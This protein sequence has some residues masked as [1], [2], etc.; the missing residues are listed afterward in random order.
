M[1]THTLAITPGRAAGLDLIERMR[2]AS[3]ATWH[4]VLAMAALALLCVGLQQ[5]DGRMIHGVSVWL[6]PAKFFASLAIQF[7]TVTWAMSYLP[8]AQL[9]QRAIRW[10]ILVMLGWGWLEMA[11][12]VFRAARAEDSHFN[13]D[14]LFA[15]VAYAVMGLGAVSMTAI[16][17]YVGFRLWRHRKDGL[18]TE[19]AALGLMVGAALGTLAGAYISQKLG[20]AVGGDPTDATG[21]GFFAWSTTG[22]DLRIAHFVGLHAAQF[23]PFAALSGKR[24]VMWLAVAA[25]TVLTAATFLQAVAGIPL[26]RG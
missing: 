20:H 25:C 13:I 26:L 21:T 15:Q 9:R 14:S 19:A 2:R 23:I 4:T 10:P 22:G 1:T 11:Y 3:P 12:I 16:A 5:L 17:A 8:A 24:S 18:M 7:A 6:K